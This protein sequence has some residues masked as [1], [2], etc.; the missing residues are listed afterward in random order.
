MANCH[1]HSLLCRNKDFGYFCRAALEMYQAENYEIWIV[2]D[3]RRK[4]DFT[5]FR[6]CFPSL[7]QTVR[8]TASE[9]TRISRG[10]Q[11]QDGV[12]NAE[13][14]CGLDDVGHFDHVIHNDG[15]TP[16]EILLQDIIQAVKTI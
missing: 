16:A 3:C 14:E 9:E 5:F 4:T 12:D 2:S 13:S 6:E 1:H 10:Y 15:N 8:I 7:C 11:F